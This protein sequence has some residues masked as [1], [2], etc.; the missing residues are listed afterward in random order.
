MPVQYYFDNL[1][2]SSF[3]RLVD[4]LLTLRYGEGVRLLPLR[5]ADGGRDAETA[6][7][8]AYFSVEIDR[9]PSLP[10]RLK[11]GRYLF[12]VK[13][14]RTTDRQGA[15]VRSAVVG[16]FA[17][18]LTSNVLSRDASDP[19]NY[20][21]LIWTVANR[22]LP[23]SALE[24]HVLRYSSN[25]TLLEARVKLLWPSQ[26]RLAFPNTIDTLLGQQSKPDTH[27]AESW[28]AA[29]FNEHSLTGLQS[30]PKYHELLVE[31]FA[32]R[33]L[34]RSFL[35]EL[36]PPM[37]PA[38]PYAVWRLYENMQILTS[39]F[40]APEKAVSPPSGP[41]DYS[42]LSES[43]ARCVA[44][45][46]ESST[47]AIESLT[48][49]KGLSKSLSKF[50]ETVDELIGLDGM[51]AWIASRCTVTMMQC[52]EAPHHMLVDGHTYYATPGR[53]KLAHVDAWVRL[54]RNLTPLFRA[55]LAVDLDKAGRTFARRILEAGLHRGVPSHVRVRGEL[56]SVP[57]M[58]VQ[59]FPSGRLEFDWLDRVPIPKYWIPEMITANPSMSAFPLRETQVELVQ[60]QSKLRPCPNEENPGRGHAID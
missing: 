37:K 59:S 44:R 18:E 36:L 3:Q 45:L 39:W 40:L 54:R 48:R 28:F 22:V 14:H 55:H 43:T 1:E 31:Q 23:A 58:L 17:N 25:H 13:H 52:T 41:I 56:Q 38:Q 26:S 27:W 34:Q 12:Q 33:P 32:F 50:F 35:A 53:P 20:F 4:V 16:D 24:G 15:A 2:A 51:P 6:A 5:G 49:G 30:T 29:V 47:A 57:R 42:G 9:S 11:P 8:T 60:P 21:F 46:I 10:P 7:P 19:V